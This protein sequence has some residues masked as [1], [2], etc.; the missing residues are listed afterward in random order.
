MEQTHFSHLELLSGNNQAIQPYMVCTMME[1]PTLLPVHL[2]QWTWNF[3]IN[4]FAERNLLNNSSPVSIHNNSFTPAPGSS[5][6]P[7]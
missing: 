4:P 5:S 1:S 3:N 7:F 2:L 6:L